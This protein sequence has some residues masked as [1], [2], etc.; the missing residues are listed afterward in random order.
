MVGSFMANIG[1]NYSAGICFTTMVPNSSFNAWVLA[2]GA[3]GILLACMG[4]SQY[5]Y[6]LLEV[7]GVVM[8]SIIV[9]TIAWWVA[10][11][12]LSPLTMLLGW[13]LGMGVG[14]GSFSGLWNITAYPML[15]AAL[16]SGIVY[17]ILN[18]LSKPVAA[19]SGYQKTE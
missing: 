12:P 18:V 8:S 13:L 9:G 19:V 6:M 15:D 10:G 1:N 3:I 2:S 7:V 5:M 14:F 16:V 11:H 4:T 17:C